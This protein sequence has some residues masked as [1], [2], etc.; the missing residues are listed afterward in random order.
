MSTKPQTCPECG[1]VLTKPRS[2][3][4]HRRFF[5]LVQKAYEHWP[6][7]QDYQPPSAEHLRAYLL[8]AAGYHDTEFIA[9]PEECLGS[10]AIMALFR[11][12]VEATHA[13]MSRR[14]GY[15]LTR[16]SA[17]GIEILTPRSINFETLSQKEFGPIREAVE[18]IITGVVGVSADQLLRERAA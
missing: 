15:S 2:L 8:V 3:P 6:H 14:R 11:S 13:A 4:D 10:P 5:G 7:A 18:E 1:C 16:V 9:M 17:G 12:A